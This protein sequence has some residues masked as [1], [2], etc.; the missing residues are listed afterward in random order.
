MNENMTG[1][2]EFIYA[3]LTNHPIWPNLYGQDVAAAAFFIH[4]E[5]LKAQREISRLRE[6]LLPFAE[7]GSDATDAEFERAR[8]V[9]NDH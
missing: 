7:F 8:E 4:E 9:L 6:A 5:R 1:A 3:L 2:K